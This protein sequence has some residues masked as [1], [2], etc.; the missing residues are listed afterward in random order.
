MNFILG[1]VFSGFAVSLVIMVPLVGVGI[2]D[3]H[4]LFGVAV[5][6]AAMAVFFIGIVVRVIDWARSPVPFR[7]PTTAGQQWSFPWIK[8]N[9][10]DNPKGNV[11]VIVRMI[12]E[13]LLFRSLFRNTRLEY[14]RDDGSSKIGYEW[15]KWLWMAAL[16]FHWSFLVIFLRHFRFFLDPIP[17]FVPLLEG[18]DGFM[19]LGVVPLG[20]LGVPG[21][22]ITDMLFLLSVTY[23]FLRRIYIPQVRYI[24]LAAD[25]FPLFLI[26]ALGL[27][28]V[29]MRYFIRV[30]ITAVKELAIGLFKFDPTVPEGI[31]VIFY[32]HL[33]VL[34]VLIAYFPFSKLMHFAGV[35]LSPTRNLSNNSRFVRH[36]NP[37][38][39]PVKFHTYEE[40]EDEFREHM[41]EA[42]L[43]VEK[44][45]ESPAESEEQE[46]QEEKE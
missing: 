39:Y 21:V 23:L 15:E 19:Q 22:Y 34:S 25:Y 20:G 12:F 29:L 24:S 35:F 10:V 38:N 5:P 28:G 27:T 42:G 32:I 43:P 40:Y 1:I 16:V 37:W 33:F 7:I 31:G 46:K 6:Y 41:V 13:V 26:L 17:G 45:P 8:S 2:L 14:L 4:I 18:L 9:P 30:D 3:L 44:Q 36:V 11:G